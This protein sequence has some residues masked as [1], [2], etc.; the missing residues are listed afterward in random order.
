M[1]NRSPKKRSKIMS[2]VRSAD[3][4]P[5]LAVRKILYSRGYRYRL[6]RKDLP[7]CP[8]IVFPGRKQ[9][10]FVHGC[11]W[12]GHR[13]RKGRFPKSHLSYW[14]PK[15]AENKKRD[16]RNTARLNRLGWRALAVWQC[17]IKNTEALLRKLISFLG[18]SNIRKQTP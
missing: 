15:I 13:C 10:V 3:T 17:E 8:D 6:H 1:D 2:A 14:K 4:G 16:A 9:A 7:G 18:R 5:E 11:F 12:H